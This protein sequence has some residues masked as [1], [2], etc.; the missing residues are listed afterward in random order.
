MIA[1]RLTVR[2]PRGAGLSFLLSLAWLH[3]VPWWR[4]VLELRWHGHRLPRALVAEPAANGPGA[5]ATV[6]ALAEILERAEVLRSEG[7]DSHGAI[8]R[9][10]QEHGASHTLARVAFAAWAFTVG[11]N[12][13]GS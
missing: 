11:G 9:A 3:A 4:S 5:L 1:I 2:W 12:E 10:V 13:L 8:V 7:H 6:N